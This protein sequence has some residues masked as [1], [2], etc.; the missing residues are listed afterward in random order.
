VN[1]H[2]ILL[3]AGVVVL[4]GLNLSEAETDEYELIC[5]P[6]KLIGAEG[7]PARVV[8]RKAL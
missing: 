4:E 8:L 3:E 2:K 6:L 5:L 1:I 7:A